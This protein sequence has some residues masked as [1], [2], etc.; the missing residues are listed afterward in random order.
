MSHLWV[1]SA[2]WHDADYVL[3]T[4][5]SGW[6]CPSTISTYEEIIFWLLSKAF[7]VCND[8]IQINHFIRLLLSQYKDTQCRA[9]QT[10]HLLLL[11][12]M[13]RKCCHYEKFWS[14][15]WF[16]CE[17]VKTSHLQQKQE[18]E[19]FVLSVIFAR[20]EIQTSNS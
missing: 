9:K 7:V 6:K 2:T 20:R 1:Y 3:G 18:V 5:L 17:H 8:S 4:T 14:T 10:T 11:K 12:F 16:P 19:I 13:P 15:L